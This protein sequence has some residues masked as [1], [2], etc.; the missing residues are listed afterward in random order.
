VPPPTPDILCECTY[1][2]IYVF[3]LIIGLKIAFSLHLRFTW[4]RFAS[5]DL[6]D[7]RGLAYPMARL[8]RCFYPIGNIQRYN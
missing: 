1:I 4:S 6:R 2:S 7:L 3:V 8:R 5:Y